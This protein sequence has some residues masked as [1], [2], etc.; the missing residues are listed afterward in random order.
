MKITMQRS[1]IGGLC[2]TCVHGHLTVFENG[3]QRLHCENYDLNLRS[4]A[5]ECAAYSSQGIK[6]AS[7]MEQREME[8]VALIWD[9]DAQQFCRPGE[10]EERYAYRTELARQ[11]ARRDAQR[12]DRSE[13][14]AESATPSQATEARQREDLEFR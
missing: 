4:P 3:A 5:A 6:W 12:Q 9:R 2:G 10:E 8:R 11:R 7:R 1:R 14:T 13:A